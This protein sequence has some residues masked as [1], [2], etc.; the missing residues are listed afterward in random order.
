[1]QLNLPLITHLFLQAELTFII[2]TDWKI[3]VKMQL[4]SL[5]LVQQ[6]AV[7]QS[8]STI[9]GTMTGL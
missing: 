8:Q 1:M 5:D 6:F 4:D 7:V 2:L 9:P 3:V